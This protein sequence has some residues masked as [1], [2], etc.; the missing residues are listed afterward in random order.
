VEFEFRCEACGEIHKGMPGFAAAAPLSYYALPE[1]ERDSRCKLGTDECV[2][3]HNSFFVRGCL[4]IPVCG[5]SE[6]LIWGV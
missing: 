3:D 1:A 2:I 4:E 6:P 5:A